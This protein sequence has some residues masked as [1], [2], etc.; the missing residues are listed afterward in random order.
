MNTTL[1][2]VIAVVAAY[3]FA[4]ILQWRRLTRDEGRTPE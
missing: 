2:I 1:L 3:V 4:C